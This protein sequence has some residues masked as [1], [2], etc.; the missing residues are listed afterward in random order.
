MALTRRRTWPFLAFAS[1]IL[2]VGL[3]YLVVDRLTQEEPNYTLIE[4]SLYVGGYVSKPPPGTKAVLNLCETGDPYQADV[5]K[6]EPIVDAEP[7]PFIDWLRQQVAF[8]EAQRQAGLPIFVHCRNGIS[9][10][11]LVVVAYEMSK[12]RW[13]RKEALSFVRAKRPGIRPNPAFMD[14]LLEWENVI[15]VDQR[16]S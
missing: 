14:L 13:T 10:S 2:C 8:I 11:G 5:M 1:A 15:K 12:K 16:R 9:R 6:W 7:V 4:D 3:V